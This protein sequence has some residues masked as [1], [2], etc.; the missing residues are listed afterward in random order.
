MME[1]VDADAGDFNPPGS[2]FGD[3]R[4]S[5]SLRDAEI[6]NTLLGFSEMIQE[7]VSTARK[8]HLRVVDASGA[9]EMI[10][11][12]KENVVFGKGQHCDVF[13]KGFFA[14]RRHAILTR[15][16]TGFQ[17]TNLA[18]LSPTRING[19]IIDSSLLC[20]GDEISMAKSIFTFHMGMN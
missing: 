19:T 13:V 16:D 1:I 4:F 18:I 20:D 2:V 9:G 11:L 5:L 6:R 17:L 3:I 14:S 8:A 12:E 7:K 10:V 15:L